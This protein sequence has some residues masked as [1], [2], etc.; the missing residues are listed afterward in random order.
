MQIRSRTILDIEIVLTEKITE[1]QIFAFEKE[2][3]K[4]LLIK[5]EIVYGDNKLS[6]YNFSGDVAVI[7]TALKTCGLTE[8]ATDLVKTETDENKTL[9][10]VFSAFSVQEIM[11][12]M[13]SLVDSLTA[14]V[15]SDDVWYLSFASAKAASQKKGLSLD[16]AQQLVIILT[17]YRKKKWRPNW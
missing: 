3:E 5:P 1:P 8:V 15:W 6:I 10:G 17:E 7:Q 9:T 4:T 2:L 14:N 12:F 13:C 16:K 11:L